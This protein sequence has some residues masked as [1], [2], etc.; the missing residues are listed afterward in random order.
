MREIGQGVKKRG[1]D[2]K[3]KSEMKFWIPYSQSDMIHKSTRVFVP[4]H[5]GWWAALISSLIHS[6]YRELGGLCFSSSR[7]EKNNGER[8]ML[9]IWHP[10]TFW[11]YGFRRASLNCDTGRGNNKLLYRLTQ[12]RNCCQKK[13]F[14]FICCPKCFR[15]KQVLHCGTN[16]E[17]TL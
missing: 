15:W 6:V 16:W 3:A 5:S 17:E 7:Q 12:S 8:W 4:R 14:L 13:L 9:V 11:V 2:E 10:C 1:K